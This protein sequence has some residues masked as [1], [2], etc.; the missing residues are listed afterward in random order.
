MGFQ[1]FNLHPRL[2]LLSIVY[3]CFLFGLFGE[4]V[5]VMAWFGLCISF[6]VVIV[7]ALFKWNELLYK[8]IIFHTDNAALV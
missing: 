4:N 6:P 7:A 2:L 1:L 8:H 3:R 5:Y